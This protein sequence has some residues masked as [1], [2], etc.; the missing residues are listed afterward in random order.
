MKQKIPNSFIENIRMEIATLCDGYYP[1]RVGA[2][3]T[4]TAPTG[5][6]HHST[7]RR[8]YLNFVNNK[9]IINIL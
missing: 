3:P 1:L 9:L 7:T 4:P 8:E 6:P 2:S 5:M